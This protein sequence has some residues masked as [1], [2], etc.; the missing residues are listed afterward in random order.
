VA[1]LETVRH[2]KR[3]KGQAARGVVEQSLQEAMG[4]DPQVAQLRQDL[5]NSIKAEAEAS[6]RSNSG[7]E[8]QI[9]QNRAAIARNQAVIGQPLPGIPDVSLARW[10]PRRRRNRCGWRRRWFRNELDL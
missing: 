6:K 7:A 1:Y 2:Y 10:Q 9:A 3:P 5:I 4:I 8:A